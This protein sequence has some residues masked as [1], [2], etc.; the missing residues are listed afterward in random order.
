MTS[1]PSVGSSRTVSCTSKLSVRQL[2]NFK[3]F[4]DFHFVVKEPIPH[5]TE[6]R[7]S[8][9]PIPNNSCVKYARKVTYCLV[10]GLEYLLTLSDCNRVYWADPSVLSIFKLELL[11]FKV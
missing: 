8:E 4:I 3:T 6:E 2:L 9:F 1:S 11:P 7:K 5:D 10:L